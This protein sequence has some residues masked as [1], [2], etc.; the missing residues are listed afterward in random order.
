MQS[1]SALY[2]FH[3]KDLSERQNGS[4]A[5]MNSIGTALINPISASARE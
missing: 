4:A 5:A 3:R 1:L 2:V